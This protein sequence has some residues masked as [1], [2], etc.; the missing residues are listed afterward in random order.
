M[1]LPA[2]AAFGPPSVALA[3]AA[4]A[5]EFRAISAIFARPVELRTLAKRT[6][7]RRAIFARPVKARLVEIAR[8]VARGTRGAFAAILALLPRLG[9]APLRAI[10]KVLAWT[11]IRP[12]A[13]ILAR[14]PIR[15]ATGEFLVAA[16]FSLGPVTITRRTRAVRTIATR[17]VTVFAKTFAAWRMGSLF[18][19]ARR[20]RLL[21]TKLSVGGSYG[22][23]GVVALTTRRAVVAAEVRAVRARAVRALVAATVFARLERTFF[24]VAT[25]RRAGGKRPIAAGTIVAIKTRPRRIAEIPAWRAITVAVAL[26][27]V[28][29][30]PARIRLLVV[31]SRAGGLA[32]EGAP[33]AVALVAIALPGKSALG[34]FL[35]RAPGGPGTA[36]A[37]RR[38]ITPAAGIVVFIV[39]AG[40]E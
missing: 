1:F 14:T 36:L 32:R 24:T 25:A 29:L 23:A 39:V 10:A 35:L 13:K 6:I 12:A 30:A 2:G 3:I 21:V 22:R 33:L 5:V 26:A 34:E 38:A 17:T 8:A 11:A 28:G 4:G 40:H 27:G 37:A 19:V 9:I 16:K 7:T 18:A 20:I 31:G 15:R